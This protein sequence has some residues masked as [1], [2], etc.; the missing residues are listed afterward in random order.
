MQTFQHISISNMYIT[1]SKK[2]NKKQNKKTCMHSF[3][4]TFLLLKLCAFLLKN[5]ISEH[6]LN[7]LKLRS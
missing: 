4:Y 1:S 7:V 5:K 6:I 2:T 3:E